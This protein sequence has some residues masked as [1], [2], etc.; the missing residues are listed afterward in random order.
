MTTSEQTSASPSA[1]Q[2]PPVSRMFGDCW[3]CRILSGS[4]LLMSAGYVF[5]A[6]RGMMRQGG[7]TTFGTVAQIAFAASLAAWG[8][9]MIADPVGKAQRKA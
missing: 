5:L 7:P 1:P 2:S 6:A 3:S 9:V 8:I 4:G